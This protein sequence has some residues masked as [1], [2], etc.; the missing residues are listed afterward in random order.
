MTREER[1]KKEEE[2]EDGIAL[3]WAV[4]CCDVLGWRPRGKSNFWSSH[5]VTEGGT[6]FRTLHISY[7]PRQQ[8]L[9]WWRF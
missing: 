6:T 2:G 8:R 3:A 5:G 7:P 9:H 1:R 4:M